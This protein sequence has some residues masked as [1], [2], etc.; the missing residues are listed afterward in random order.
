M[1]LTRA[2]RL[3]PILRIV[4]P[5]VAKLLCTRR[6]PD[7]KCLWKALQR[8]LGKSERFEARVGDPDVQP[9]IGCDPRVCG[10]IDI[11]CQPTEERSARLS[12]LDAQEHMRAEIRR[13][14]RSKDGRLDV[15]QLER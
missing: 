2:E 1:D 7:A 13:R 4:D 11:R 5:I 15:V 8:L 12:I 9:G 3:V 6:H 10:R 14:S